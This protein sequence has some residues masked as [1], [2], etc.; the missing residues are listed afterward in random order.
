MMNNSKTIADFKRA[1]SLGTFWE[2]IHQYTDKEP[3]SLGVRE[4][5]NNNT[6][7]FGFRSENTELDGEVV[8]SYC[9]WPKKNQ[10][11]INKSGSVVITHSWVKLIYTQKEGKS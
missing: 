7:G 11:S 4:C 9:G 1:M 5:L 6:V 10:F 3:K 8:I 2:C